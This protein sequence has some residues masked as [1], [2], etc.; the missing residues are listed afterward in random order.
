MQRFSVV[1]DLERQSEVQSSLVV[2]AEMKQHQ[3]CQAQLQKDVRELRHNISRLVSTS[4]NGATRSLVFNRFIDEQTAADT[5]YIKHCQT[6][7]NKMFFNKIKDSF[8]VS[9]LCLLLVTHRFQLSCSGK[10][11]KV[12]LVY[13]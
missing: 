12:K 2:K 9:N 8:E 4:V 1:D 7:W 10:T 6:T 5:K 13:F 11:Y 3:I